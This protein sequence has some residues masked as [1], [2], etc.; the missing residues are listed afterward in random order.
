M[1]VLRIRF[2]LAAAKKL[3]LRDNDARP[4]QA[5]AEQLVFQRQGSV[6]PAGSQRVSLAQG[7]VANAPTRGAE[8]QVLGWRGARMGIGQGISRRDM[9]PGSQGESSERG[10]NDRVTAK[11]LRLAICFSPYISRRTLGFWEARDKQLFIRYIAMQ[12]KV[13]NAPDDRTYA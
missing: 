2:V 12:G 13:A 10:C 6:G 5:V 9:P 7:A 11:N 8:M 3:D 4:L 1:L